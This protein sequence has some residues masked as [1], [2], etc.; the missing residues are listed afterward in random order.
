[1]TR[2][3]FIKD[4][5][6][7]FTTSFAA[8]ALGAAFGIQS[9]RGALAGMIAAA[10]IPIIASILGG[11]RLQASGPTA[12]MAAVTTLIVAQAYDKFGSQHPNA[13]QLITLVIL[14]SAAFTILAGA[15]RAGKLIAYVPQVVVLGFMNGIAVLIWW[16]QIKKLFGLG[17]SA[18]F[19]GVIWQNSA[20]AFATFVAILFF[21]WLLKK[22]KVPDKIKS[23]IPGTFVVL[24]SFTLI[25]ILSKLNLQTVKLGG[26]ISSVG[27]FFGLIGKFFPSVEILK[28]EYFLLALPFALQLTLL[29]YL[30]S[31]LT[32]LVIDKITNEKTNRDKELFAQGL[33]NGVA[34]IF[35]GIPG[36]QATI[37]SVILIKEGAQTRLAGVLVGVFTLAGIFLFQGVI[38][39]VASAIFAGVLIKA[40]LDVFEKDYLTEFF[41]N[42]RYLDKTHLIQLGFVIY[43]TLI[44]VFLD[45]NTAVISATLLFYIGKRFFKLSDITESSLSD[46]LVSE[47]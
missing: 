39:M 36:A 1:M 11:T 27:E 28:S 41:S 12:P 4:L 38:G 19:D 30:D 47:G 45:L 24:I 18:A 40:G 9:G 35:G 43:T 14:M 3:V 31:L 32:S 34:A 33:A 13:E 26:Q 21:P 23:F 2:Q 20:F 25:F 37:R 42:K 10:I 7:G 22:L 44:T 29:G 17:G 15:L 46:D 5:L 16:D 8:I 6:A